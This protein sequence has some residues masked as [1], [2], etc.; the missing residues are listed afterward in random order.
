MK[1]ETKIT[2]SFKKGVD[3]A[4][5]LSEEESSMC[6]IM[7][8]Q[9]AV[10]NNQWVSFHLE[11]TQTAGSEYKILFVDSKTTVVFS[12]IIVFYV[13]SRQQTSILFWFENLSLYSDAPTRWCQEC[14]FRS[15]PCSKF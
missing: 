5:K 15:K 1:K 11:I 13:S 2:R 9:K 12:E 14:N 8:H 4:H 10:I 6:L 7:T 3:D